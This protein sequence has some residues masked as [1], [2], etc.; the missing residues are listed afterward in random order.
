[1]QASY[2]HGNFRP[3][4]QYGPQDPVG[5]QDPYGEPG[6]YPADGEYEDEYEAGRRFV[7]GFGDDGDADYEG[8]QPD[9]RARRSSRQDRRQDRRPDSRGGGR[10]GSVLAQVPL[11]RPLAAL[12]VIVIPLAVGGVYLYSLYMGKYHP[13]DYAG[14]GTGSVVVQVTS[15]DTPTSL[16]PKL[17][18]LGVVAS[19]ASAARR[20]QFQPGLAARLLRDAQAHAGVAGLRAAAQ[21]EGPGTGDLTILQRLAERD[22][23]LAR[24]QIRHPGQRLRRAQNLV[25]LKLPSYANGKPGGLPVPRDLRGTAARDRPRR[26]EGH[27]AAVRPGGGGG[28][29]AAGAKRVGPDQVR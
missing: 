16:A 7:P 27:G 21:S 19:S 13:A 12:S 15:G 8:G 14:E 11:D 3:Q 4:D 20:A 9:R 29:P 25:S 10:G 22:H 6:Q 5:P 2:D 26:A 18:Q 17:V 28:E 24:R 23:E 1:M